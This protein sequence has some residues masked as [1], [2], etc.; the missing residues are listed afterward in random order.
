M[1]YQVNNKAHAVGIADEQWMTTWYD[2][3]ISKH[4]VK[5]T[6]RPLLLIPILLLASSVHV[7][8]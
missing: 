3:H 6:S 5:L 7:C 2:C 8:N 4:F 1:L